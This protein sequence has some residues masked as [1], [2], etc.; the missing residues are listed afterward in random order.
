V[1][2]D[3]QI[4]HLFAG[5]PIAD[6]DR[7]VEWYERLLGRAPDILP[8]AGEAMWSVTPTGSIY[9]VQTPSGAG[10][11]VVTVAV[12]DLDGLLAGLAARGIEAGPVEQVGS[13]GRKATV[14]DPDGSRISFVELVNG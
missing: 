5:I 11:T 13:A 3:P 10:G 1:G 8:T 9:I 2:A 12:R 7:A 6:Y 14:V 4:S